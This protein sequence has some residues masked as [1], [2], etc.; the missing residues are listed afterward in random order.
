MGVQENIVMFNKSL[1]DHDGPYS[2]LCLK[3]RFVGLNDK[4]AN[5]F[6]VIC[7]IILNFGISLYQQVKGTS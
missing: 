1:S 2:S 3:T 4:S 6:A 5:S 7:R